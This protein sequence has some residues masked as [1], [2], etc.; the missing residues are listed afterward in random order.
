MGKEFMKGLNE[1]EAAFVLGHELA[2]IRL[3]HNKH[4]GAGRGMS[5][6]SRALF[7]ASGLYY[8][9]SLLARQMGHEL[10]MVSPDVNLAIIAN[11]AYQGL[12]FNIQS[13]AREYEADK[14]GLYYADDIEAARSFFK[15]LEKSKR[16]R[17]DLF[18]THPH[19]RKRIAAL[20]KWAADNPYITP[21]APVVAR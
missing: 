14:G 7:W 18:S 17:W 15:K 8:G 4:S 1:R 13:H 9:V 3:H 12:A 2:H 19:P 20:E 5:I 16:P 21:S 6:L 10:P 11:T